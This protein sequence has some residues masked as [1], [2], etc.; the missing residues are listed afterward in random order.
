VH[1]LSEPY[2]SRKKGGGGKAPDLLS[3]IPVR[4]KKK[5]K[6][7]PVAISSRASPVRGGIK[8]EVSRKKPPC[9]RGKG[10]CQINYLRGRALWFLKKKENAISPFLSKGGEERGRE[11]DL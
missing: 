11:P 1:H 6:G 9:A 8:K 2:R 10:L 5:K 4:K 7:K 3:V